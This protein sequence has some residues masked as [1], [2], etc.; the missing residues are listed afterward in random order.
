MAS[1]HDG[2][3]AEQSTNLQGF[4]EMVVE[5]YQKIK[6]NAETY[7]YVWGSYIVVYGGFALWTTYRWRKL[8]KTEDR[9]RALQERLRKLVDSQESASTTTQKIPPS[10][11]KSPSPK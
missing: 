11:D 3:K 5:Q 9:V 4:T 8:R 10:I 1:E 2:E 6:E 7:P